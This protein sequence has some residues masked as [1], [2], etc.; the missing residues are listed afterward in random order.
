[1]RAGSALVL[2]ADVADEDDEHGDEGEAEE[3]E[4]DKDEE[5]HSLLSVGQR[6]DGRDVGGPSHGGRWGR[7]GDGCSR[8]VVADLLIGGKGGDGADL[9]GGRIGQ[10]D[11]VGDAPI[12]TRR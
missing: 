10:F 1:M 9:A 8:V 3:H 11:E 12:G 6:D 7:S 2:G 5:R 4:G